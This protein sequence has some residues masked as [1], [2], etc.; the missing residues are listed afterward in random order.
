MTAVQRQ[1]ICG[2][3]DL[4]APG[5]R[6]H[7]LNVIPFRR[8]GWRP[9]GALAGP[10]IRTMRMLL[11]MLAQQ[12]LSI[13]IAVRRPHDRVNML[14]MRDQRIVQVP[15][16]NRALMVELDQYHR[17]VNTVIKNTV[18]VRSSDPGEEGAIQMRPYLVHFDASMTIVHVGDIE[19]NQG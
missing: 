10:L 2:D 7:I 17:T 15:Q 4:I 13:V 1:W 9:H 18:R 11:I 19:R 14:P 6:L 8:K 12:V 5:P 16:S 3:S